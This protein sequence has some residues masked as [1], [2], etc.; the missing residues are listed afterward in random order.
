MQSA[1]ISIYGYK[2]EIKMR[3]RARL[4]CATYLVISIYGYDIEMRHLSASKY[5]VMWTALS[6]MGVRV[7]SLWALE[8]ELQ[9]LW[10]LRWACQ[11]RY[12]GRC[13][14]LGQSISIVMGVR[15]DAANFSLWVLKRARVGVENFFGV[16]R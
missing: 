14:L 11:T 9:H 15:V 2:S 1:A 10:A 5:M 4:K 6:V 16:N 13:K 3:L 7:G 8:W 12:S